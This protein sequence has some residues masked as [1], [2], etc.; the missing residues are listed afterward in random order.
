MLRKV[1]PPHVKN[2]FVCVPLSRSNTFRNA[3]S[4]DATTE[5]DE[6]QTIRTDSSGSVVAAGSVARKR[7]VSGGC[8]VVAEFA[9][10]LALRSVEG[11]PRQGAESTPRTGEGVVYI[12]ALPGTPGMAL[13]L[14]NINIEDWPS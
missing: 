3:I 1:P 6:T 10:G 2:I 9:G 13:L 12:P 4:R 7:I 8:V 14:L 11:K 5:N